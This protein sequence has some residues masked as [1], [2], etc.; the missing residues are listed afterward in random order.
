M[1]LNQSILN[2]RTIFIEFTSAGRKTEKRTESLRIKNEKASRFKL[3]AGTSKVKN[4]NNEKQNNK[5]QSDNKKDKG[6]LGRNEEVNSL[7][8]DIATN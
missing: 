3:A 5:S 8:M 2:D 6:K 4:N 7:L 1:Q